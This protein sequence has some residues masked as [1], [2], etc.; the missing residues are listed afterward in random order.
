MG[1]ERKTI[2]KGLRKFDGNE[3]RTVEWIL[4]GSS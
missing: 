2:V 4:S 1:F 3:E